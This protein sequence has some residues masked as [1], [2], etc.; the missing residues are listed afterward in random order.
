MYDSP[1]HLLNRYQ[2]LYVSTLTGNAIGPFRVDHY[3][4][5]S[6]DRTSPQMREKEEIIGRLYQALGRNRNTY[7]YIDVPAEW[8]ILFPEQRIDKQHITHALNGGGSPVEIENTLTAAVAC[9]HLRAERTAIQQFLTRFVGLDCCGFVGNYFQGN[10]VRMGGSDDD[11]VPSPRT[12]PNGYTA[13]GST[14][15]RLE[16]I[17]SNDILLFPIAPRS[18]RHIAL[19]DY[20]VGNECMVCESHG[21]VGPDRRIYHL[22]GGPH[23]LTA[24]DIMGTEH[25]PESELLTFAF[26]HPQVREIELMVRQV[27]AGSMR[28]AGHN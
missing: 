10:N 7:R 18:R 2:T 21:G 14:V 28:R 5:G 13:W 16:D 9:G 24:G 1:S 8:A 25:L 23:R 15:H 17:A 20:R 6:D 19:I 26:R 3:Q 12:P 11:P 4:A 22:I 27:C